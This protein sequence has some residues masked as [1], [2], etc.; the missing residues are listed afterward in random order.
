MDYRV[1]VTGVDCE[2][3]AFKEGLTLLL[4]LPSKSPGFPRCGEPVPGAPHCCKHY[5]AFLTVTDRILETES[6]LS[7]VHCSVPYF[8]TVM[9]ETSSAENGA[10]K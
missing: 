6:M 9:E 2:R 5:S 1:K 7:S 3:H 10:K 8:V 4:F